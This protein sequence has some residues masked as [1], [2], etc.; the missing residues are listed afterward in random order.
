M[1][2]EFTITR[3]AS[4]AAGVLSALGLAYVGLS[5]IWN[6]PFGDQVNQ[7]IGVLVQFISAVL[8]VYT[9]KKIN[10]AKNVNKALS[11]EELG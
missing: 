4:I 5:Q 1:E 2:K 7:T 11:D 9:G 6:L 3:V 8:A 10:D